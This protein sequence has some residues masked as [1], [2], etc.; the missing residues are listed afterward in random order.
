VKT[1]QQKVLVAT[2]V[3]FGA[4]SE[5]AW[6]GIN[7]WTSIG[8]DGGYIQALAIDPQ[9]PGTVYASTGFNVY[10]STDGAVKRQFERHT[11]A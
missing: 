6:A 5:K 3:M 9:N 1:T 8:P 11:L 10:R 2:L 7:E 4:G